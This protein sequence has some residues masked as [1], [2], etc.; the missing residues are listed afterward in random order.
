MDIHKLKLV[1]VCIKQN[2]NCRFKQW[3]QSRHNSGRY[4]QWL[5]YGKP[6]FL[7]YESING[8]SPPSFKKTDIS[9]QIE[10]LKNASI[11][12]GDVDN[13]QDI[14]FIISG[15]NDQSGTTKFSL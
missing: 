15:Y 7:L 10:P 14:D 6:K 13:D 4:D 11:D 1:K 8:S 2:L 9:S 12:L 5:S 3:W